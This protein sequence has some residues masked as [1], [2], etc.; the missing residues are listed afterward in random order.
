MSILIT[1]SCSPESNFFELA[2]RNYHKGNY[3]MIRADL[4]S[5]D[6][7]QLESLSVNDGY[8]FIVSEINSVVERHIPLK[9]N[10]RT[11]RKKQWVN[12]E[13]IKMVKNKYK[14]WKS[15][16]HAK[17]AENYRKYRAARNRCSNVTRNAKRNFEKH[18]VNDIKTNTKG[19]WSYVREQTNSRTK[20]ADL[21]DRHGN[22]ITDNKQK[23]NLL[24]DFFASVFV[25]EPPG[26]LP[27]FDIRYN[28][29]VTPV[30]KLTVDKSTVLKQLKG[31]NVFKSMGPDGCHPRI[32]K[33][34]AEELCEPLCILMNKTFEEQCI[35]AFWKQANVSALFK[36][37]GERTDPSNYRPV[38]LTCIP[39]KLCE[40]TVREVLMKHMNDNNLFSDCQYGFREKRSCILQ[41]LDVL[42]DLT[43]AYDES[44]QTDV[45]YIDIKKAFDSIPHRRLLLKLQAY[46]FG[47][48]ILCWIE[49][50]LKGR[51]QKVNVNG[52][53][54]EWQPITSGIPQGS[55]LGPV[56]FII[57][58]ND[59]PDKLKSMCK[60]FADDSK[61][62][63]SIQDEVDQDIIQEDLFEICDWTDI[64]LLR[65]SIPKC[66]AIQYGYIRYENVYQL[67][68]QDN[69]VLDIPAAE[70]EKDLGITFEKSLKFDKHVLNV[71]NR[72]KKLTGLIKR[73]FRYMDKKLFLQL[74]K[75]LI[76]SIVDYG[77]VV[78]YPSTRKNI[79]LI[80]NIQKRA[81]KIVPELKDLPYEQRLRMLN[82]P[83]LLYRRQRFDL[84][85]IFKIIN[86]FD[87][88]DT[89]KFFTFN[90]NNTRGHLFRLEK[91]H[92]RKSLRLNSF[93]TRCINEWNNLPEEIVCKTSI[94]GFKIALDKLWHHK[95]FDTSTIY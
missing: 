24:N 62:Y 64:W 77:I 68:D 59:L 27:I 35:P 83:T 81:T 37:K 85:Q 13:C 22:L 69:I 43:S 56:L 76:R 46:G 88:I 29:T 21:K 95:R 28:G 47:D 40:K 14:A 34:A 8:N 31:L 17:T 3:D 7:K 55:V 79:Q 89:D 42:D 67:R 41:L 50:F 6:W 4:S 49:D 38:S 32:L 92:V 39:C 26:P 48:E 9:S 44:K 58:I 36:N 78:W 2:K 61:I 20:M 33:E 91:H 73:T 5:I 71:V 86:G 90:D 65:I 19:F 70:E 25:N 10:H 12:R 23:A 74:F 1:L 94:D 18:I 80:E 72:C 63:R 84:I 57:Y 87:N 15:Y 16:I 93:P 60:I 11:V 82:L 45:I 30:S 53:F 75:T 66:K 54:S 51:K 52:E